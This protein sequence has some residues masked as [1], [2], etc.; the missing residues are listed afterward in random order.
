[1][2]LLSVAHGIG[3]IIET[4]YERRFDQVFGLQAMGA[5][6]QIHEQTAVISGVRKLSAALVS[7]SDLRSAASLVIAAVVAE[8]VSVVQGTKY[9]DRGYHDLESKLIKIGVNIQRSPENEE[10]DKTETQLTVSA[11]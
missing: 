2:V 6:I 8:G 9:I 5:N 7:R 4:I 11:L 1:M 10:I 3:R